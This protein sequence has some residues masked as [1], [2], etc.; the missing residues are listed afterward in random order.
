MQEIT[1]MYADKACCLNQRYVFTL[2]K[3]NINKDICIPDPNRTKNPE[4]TSISECSFLKYFRI[5]IQQL[6]FLTY[7]TRAYPST[8]LNK[9]IIFPASVDLEHCICTFQCFVYNLRG[10]NK[11]FLYSNVVSNF[12]EIPKL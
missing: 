6:S 1:I 2:S 5:Q 3:Q 7:N 8:P 11:A 12:L 10:P 4:V 9:H